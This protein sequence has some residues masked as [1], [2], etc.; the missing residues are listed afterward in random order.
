MMEKRLMVLTAVFAVFAVAAALRPAPKKLFRTED[1]LYDNT[2]TKLDDYQAALE[3]GEKYSYK[4]PEDTYKILTPYGIDS[5]VFV[6]STQDQIDATVIMSNTR[7]SFHSPEWCFP[8]QGWEV[9]DDSKTIVHTKTQGDIPFTVFHTQHDRQK[10]WAVFTYKDANVF[11]ASAGDL[12]W[13]W[14]KK[15]FWSGDPQEGAFFRF[16]GE[17]DRLSR[18]D[19]LK[20]AADYMDEVYRTSKGVL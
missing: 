15:Q 9:L 2:P 4:M 3:P 20:F 13:D 18:E 6:N 17:T 14:S 16:I 5:R 19:V 1:W 11:Y 10:L 8:G 12:W 7:L